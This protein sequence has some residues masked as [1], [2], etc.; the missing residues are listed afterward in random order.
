LC[1]GRRA[2]VHRRRGEAAESERQE[3]QADCPHA[4]GT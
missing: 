3:D 4:G 1:R 2:L